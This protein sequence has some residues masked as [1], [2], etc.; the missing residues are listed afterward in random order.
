MPK[1]DFDSKV[2]KNNKS[3]HYIIESQVGHLTPTNYPMSL[4]ITNP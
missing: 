4:N 1:F 3:N 2:R